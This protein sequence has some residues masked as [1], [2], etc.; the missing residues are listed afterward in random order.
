MK[1]EEQFYNY[2]KYKNYSMR[3]ADAYWKWCV[4]FF[5]FN[6]LKHPSETAKKV[7]D[8]LM[9]LRIEKNLAPKSIRQVGYALIFLYNKILKMEIPEYVDLPKPSNRKPP[10]VFSRGEVRAI[11]DQ[12][13]N[14]NLL[15][16]QIMYG[17]GLRVSECL[18]LRVKDIDF[19]NSQILIYNGKGQKSDLG[20]LPEPIVDDLR[21]QIEK[22]R[23]VYQKDLLKNYSGA[24]LPDEVKQKYSSVAKAFEWQ[25]IFPASN[26]C[27]DKQRH[28]IHQSVIQ[29][30]VKA[31]IKKAKV[32]KFGSCHT[33]RHSFATHLLQAGNDIR[34][35]QEL[36]RH[37][38]IGTTMIY[39]HVLDTEKRKVISPLAQIEPVRKELRIVKIA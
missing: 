12:L 21:L 7:N 13:T 11:L 4:K 8:Y 35:V 37:K 22:A 5:H 20:L 24:T 18:S 10:V 17:S 15:I 30:A 26:Y 32:E 16:A 9:H 14:E 31:A 39:T 27:E 33:L 34:T 19:A 36:L 38:R 29:K 23:V 3:T 2:M 1:L 6:N 25:Y 28:H